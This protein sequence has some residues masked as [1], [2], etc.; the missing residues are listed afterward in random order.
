MILD[1]HEE[2]R[3]WVYMTAPFCHRVVFK[4]DDEASPPPGDLTVRVIVHGQRHLIRYHSW[5]VMRHDHGS[6]MRAHLNVGCRRTDSKVQRF[7]LRM[8]CQDL[9]V[10]LADRREEGGVHIVTA[11]TLTDVHS[12]KQCSVMVSRW[13]LPFVIVIAVDDSC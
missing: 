5:G 11:L 12:K 13:V 6:I 1:T 3:D 8:A 10:L 9:Q 4:P 7:L 2:T